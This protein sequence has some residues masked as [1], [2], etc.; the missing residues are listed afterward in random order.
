VFNTQRMVKEY[1]EQLY[2]AAAQARKFFVTLRRSDAPK[3]MEN[4]DA[5]GL[6]ASS[7]V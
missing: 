4:A 2:I 5:Q 1:A 7:G 6:A 3:P